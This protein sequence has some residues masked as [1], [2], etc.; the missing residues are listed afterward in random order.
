MNPIYSFSNTLRSVF[1]F[2][3]LFFS[4][5]K[6]NSLN[7]FPFETFFSRALFLNCLEKS[8]YTLRIMFHNKS[9]LRETSTTIE[10][11][12]KNVQ[13]QKSCEKKNASVTQKKREKLVL[14]NAKGFFL[15]VISYALVIHK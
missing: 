14:Y 9:I 7:G 8:D 3:F 4:I 15:V 2:L 5:F 1:I 12:Y 10:C 13:Q 11:A 6:C